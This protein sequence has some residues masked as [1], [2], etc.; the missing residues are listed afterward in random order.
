MENTYLTDAELPATV[1]DIKSLQNKISAIPA[2]PA[3]PAGLSGDTIQNYGG[4]LVKNGALELGTLEGWTGGVL[5]QELDCNVI[6]SNIQYN[7][8]HK[9]P[10]IDKNYLYSI[11]FEGQV[12]SGSVSMTVIPYKG[13]LG[14]KAIYNTDNYISS[15]SYQRKKFFFGG[16]GNYIFNFSN[17]TETLAIRIENLGPGTYKFKKIVLKQVLL[18]EPVPFNLP[19][20]PIGQMVFDPT[21]GAVGRYDGTTIHWFAMA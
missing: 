8:S 18:G 19:Y 6:E 9:S 17:D 15:N 2:G 20:L 12:S 14:I 7:Q 16:V 4:S 5:I 11:E 10:K 1:A 21:D 13:S 3:G